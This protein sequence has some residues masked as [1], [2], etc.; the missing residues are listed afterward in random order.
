MVVIKTTVRRVAFEGL[1]GSCKTVHSLGS[2][3]VNLK[4]PDLWQQEAVRS[5]N[6]GFDVVVD[7]PTGAGK[8]YIFELLVE[9]GLRRQAIYTVPTRALANDKLIEWRAR[10]WD[11]GIATG[12]VAENLQAPVVVATLETQRSRF[13]ERRGPGL[14]VVDEYQML[15]DQTRGVSYELAIAMVPEDTQLLLL[16]GSVGNAGDVAAWLN[17][18]G[19]RASLVSFRTRPVPLDEVYLD[20]LNERVPS[21]VRGFW[22]RLIARALMA[23]LGPI[24]V[25]APQRKAAEKLARH[26]AGALPLLDPL[27]LSKEQKAL[28]GDR[29]GKLIKTRVAFHHSGLS[30][31]QRAGVVEPLAKAGQLRVVVATTGL[32]AGINF[33]MRSV[34]VTDNEYTSGHLQCLIRPDEL[35]QMFGRAG[36]RG[37]DEVGYVLVAPDRPRLSEARPLTVRRPPNLEWP[38]LI[39]VMHAAAERGDDPFP[40][41]LGLMGRLYTEVVPVLGVERSLQSGAMPCGLHIDTQR[42]RLA[43]P[44]VVEMLDSRGVWVQRPEAEEMEL[45]R[46]LRRTGNCWRPILGAAEGLA[47]LGK[48][49]ICRW[50]DENGKVFGRQ[51]IVGLAVPDRDDG[52]RLSKSVRA[53]LRARGV[54]GGHLRAREWSETEIRVWLP[55]LIGELTDGGQL[56]DLAERSGRLV[57][58]VGYGHQKVSAYPDDHGFGLLE[59]P[60]R[61]AYPIEC[62]HC[63]ELPICE[64][65]LSPR[66]TPASAWH[67]LGLIDRGGRPTRRGILFS[68][69]HHGEGLAVAAALEDGAYPVEDLAHDLAN[70][71]AGH[72]FEEFAHSSSRLSRACRA[73]YGEASFE[74]YLNRGLPVHY[75]DGAA[76]VLAETGR[77]QKGRGLFNELLRP[78]DVERARLEW[79]SLL[80]HI[81]HAPDL[82]WDR[83]Q[84]LKEVVVGILES[85]VSA[86][87]VVH[88]P[89]LTSAQSKRISHRLRFR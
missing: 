34:L 30:Y 58:R 51:C 18:I 50:S 9:K 1:S 65:Q 33:S 54:E 23:D 80:R 28:A 5:L 42:A 88:P 53:L 41:A 47:G 87:D 45:T 13:L 14:L 74:G 2:L 27:V 64:H 32:A 16:S 62:Q 67:R 46:V 26:I 37:L 4:I 7:A 24:L 56:H 19:R 83:W 61:K 60:D 82:Q 25:F 20:S 48:G 39:A 15:A 6:Q 79:W 70:L 12:D 29:L 57:A 78:G 66:S 43:R 8:T 75:G 22:P 10:G 17:R 68:F 35:L 71:R 77:T 36:R 85:D 40:T 55:D 73:V 31:Q 76:E 38:S 59:P 89:V 86:V 52:Y 72:R 3:E 44:I 21:S 11:V 63:S 69:F 84:A 49:P 81:V